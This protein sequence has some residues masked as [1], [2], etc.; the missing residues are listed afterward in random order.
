VLEALTKLAG[1]RTV[2]G[3][4]LNPAAV[5]A[6]WAMAD[7][8]ALDGSDADATAV[9]VQALGHPSA[10]VRKTT[11]AVLP[12]TAES[13]AAVLKGKVLDDR[14]PVVR[15]A[16]LLA[17]SEMPASEEAGQAVYAALSAV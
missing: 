6:L 5:H 11:L 9:A 12:R 13:A 3:I 17:L 7:L 1:D 8:G 2:D 10:G 16:A 15:K 4:G 14:D